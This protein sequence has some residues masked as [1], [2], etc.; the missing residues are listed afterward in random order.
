VGD[1]AEGPKLADYYMSIHYGVC[2]GPINA[3]RR[4]FIGGKRAWR[5][6]VTTQ[7]VFRID[8]PDLYEGDEQEGGV[9]GAVYF[10]PGDVTQVLPE[11]LAG[12]LDLT[13]DTCPAFRGITSIW[14][15]GEEDEGF[16]FVAGSDGFYWGTN[17]PYLKPTSV[18]LT[19]IPE[20]WYGAKAPIPRSIGEPEHESYIIDDSTL[21]AN[22]Q[23]AFDTFG[24]RN[25]YCDQ[26]STS[27]LVWSIPDNTLTTISPGLG[28]LQAV[29]LTIDGLVVTRDWTVIGGGGDIYFF[30][31]SGTLVSTISG[32]LGALFKSHATTIC[33][34]VVANTHYTFMMA[35]DSTSDTQYIRITDHTAFVQ[36]ATTDT[37]PG[38]LTLAGDMSIG[39][40]FAYVVDSATQVARVDWLETPITST[41]VT[42]PS[43][44]D[45]IANCAYDDLTDSVIIVCANGDLLK[46]SPD[47]TTLLASNLLT[48]IGAVD[49]N[50]NSNKRMCPGDGSIVILRHQGPGLS[51]KI[52][53]FSASDLSEID[54]YDSSNMDWPN[55]TAS[56]DF[57]KYNVEFSAFM[58][59]QHSVRFSQWFLPAADIADMNPSHIIYHALT[60]TDWG[61]ASPLT[62]IDEASFIAAAD[63]LFTEEFGLSLAWVQQTTIEEF[64]KDILNHI[65]ATLFVR[66]STGLLTLK[67]IR[68]DY[69]VADLP[70]L[71]RDNSR[72]MSYA[73][74]GWGD[75]VNEVNIS[76]TNPENEEDETITMQDLGNISMQGGVVSTS[77]NYHGIRK[78]DLA[79]RVAARDITAESWPI[80]TAQVEVNR[81]AWDYVPGDCVKL[82]VDEY[83]ISLLVMRITTVDYGKPGDSK[84]KLSLV[85]DIFGLPLAEFVDQPPGSLWEDPSEDPRPIDFALPLTLTYFHAK[86]VGD[87][88]GAVY[89]EVR[90]GM[91]AAQGGSDTVNYKLLGPT[92]DAA[93][94]ETLYSNLGTRSILSRATLVSGFDAEAETIATSADWT[95]RS[96][97]GGPL[98]GGFI[99]IGDGE[100][101]ENELALITSTTGG[102]YTLMRGVLDTVPQDWPAATPIWFFS[103]NSRVNDPIVRSALDTIS[104]KVLPNTTNGT[105]NAG[106]ASPIPLT[107]TERPWLPTR[108]ADVTVEGIGF[109]IVDVSAAPPADVL[110]EWALR[111]RLTEDSQVLAWDA[112][113]VTAEASQTTTVEVLKISDRSVITA[114]TGLSGSS[115]A[116]PVASFGAFGSAIVRVTSERDG[117]E[118]LQGH[119][120][121][122]VVGPDALGIT[123]PQGNLVLST[124]APSVENVTPTIVTPPAGNLVLSSTAPVLPILVLPPSANLVLSSTA[125]SVGINLDP[126][127]ASVVF[128]S[129]FDGVDGA[130]AATDDSPQANTIIFFGNAQLDTAQKKFGTASLLLDGTGDRIHVTEDGDFD[131]GSGQFTL[132]CWVRFNTLSSTSRGIM[133]RSGTVVNQAGWTFNATSADP[134][135]LGFAYS[136]DGG[137]SFN[138]VVTTSGAGLTTG[139]WYHLATDRD[140]AG[141]IRIYVDGVMRG[142]ATP[143]NPAINTEGGAFALGATDGAGSNDTDGW[144]DE[145]RVTKG[146]ARYASD[147]GFTVP[148][149]AYPR[150]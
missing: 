69:V 113:G 27:I 12:R 99:L 87:V 122:V 29:H 6:N 61:M 49:F 57:V 53:V 103:N 54:R 144:F 36:T 32:T 28:T 150:S 44:T 40:E 106:A 62:N 23:N 104:Y 116:L 25:A 111:N 21:T 10:L 70:V 80:A 90:A 22:N 5:G 108:P 2:W 143:A 43:L 26:N 142:S 39:P 112:A 1:K 59:V 145:P 138:V 63:T 118:S 13:S 58:M 129:S 42:P 31:L 67:L 127:F 34:I 9:G 16:G 7:R 76:W 45:D 65:N 148:A 14:M 77:K 71:D 82:T 107:L 120:I 84:I 105:L 141:K 56:Y 100:E 68:N 78:P 30:D 46:Y 93:G 130:T 38:G 123:P 64:I 101:T 15:Y 50:Q 125:P 48:G 51:W 73:R 86:K 89:P 19:C 74:K 88:S 110:V 134:S 66:P 140:G 96:Q 83:G 136:T 91:F 94:N 95:T 131:F 17:N 98:A 24:F 146:V 147:G 109:G 132:E 137:A 75:T 97:G 135:N 8:E 81:E 11:H 121:I 79:K 35:T 139:V 55:P 20:D 119:E 3:L 4:L 33:D 18:E 149:A 115:F 72:V 128:L 37:F 126:H 41:V 117:Y 133:S 114:H 124:A 92:V 47:L 102:N 52:F 60:N 85:E